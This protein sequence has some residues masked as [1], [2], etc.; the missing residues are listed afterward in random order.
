ML[1]GDAGA[2][3]RVGRHLT[4]GLRSRLRNVGQAD[5]Y[6]AWEQSVMAAMNELDDCILQTAPWSISVRLLCSL[7]WYLMVESYWISFLTCSGLNW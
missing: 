1:T 4:K 7:R 6:Y 5:C 2:P 3:A